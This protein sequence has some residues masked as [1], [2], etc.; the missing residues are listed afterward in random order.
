MHIWLLSIC[1]Q[2]W[3]EISR[4]TSLLLI[5]TGTLRGIP[6]FTSS[7]FSQTKRKWGV[8]TVSL[9]IQYRITAQLSGRNRCDVTRATEHVRKNYWLLEPFSLSNIRTA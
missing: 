6:V 8:N 5:Q 7:Q 4:T 3:G 1:F 9:R 2:E